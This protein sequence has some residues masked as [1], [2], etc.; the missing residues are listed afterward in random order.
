MS[1]TVPRLDL[2]DVMPTLLAAFADDP[3]ARWLYPDDG[4]YKRAFPDLVMLSGG[5]GFE[6]G[7]VDVAEGGAAVAVWAPPGAEVDLEE[8]GAAWAAH[9]QAHV[10]PA[11]LGDVFAWGEQIGAFH[12]T[13]SYWYLA[14][15]GVAPGHQGC[16]HGTALLQVGLARCDR[17]GLPAHLES[18]N[19]RNHRFYERHGFE[20]IGEIQVA[21]SPTVWPMRRLPGGGR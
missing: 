5:A 7:T 21:D 12:P 13:G 19:P 1:A 2:A 9:F 4:A 3:A 14:Q 15:I 11:R 18:A 10:D 8:V 17:D 16:G 20:V 6:E